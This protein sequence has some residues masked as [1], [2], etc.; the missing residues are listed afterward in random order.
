MRMAFRTLRVGSSLGLSS[1]VLFL[2][3]GGCSSTVG[4]GTRGDIGGEQYRQLETAAITPPEQS[5]IERASHAIQT[6]FLIVMENHN[7]S[8]IAGNASAP[9]INGTLL[10]MGAH[11]EHYVNGAVHPSEPNYVWLEAGDALGISNDAA[12]AYNDR[13]THAH[14]S[15]FLDGA[16]VSWKSYQEDIAPDTC[17]LSASGLY[18]PKHNPM[19][20]F[21]DV[22]ADC[23][24]HVRPYGELARDLA[25]GTVAAYNFITPNLCDDMHNADGCATGDAVANGDAWLAREVPVILASEAYQKGGAL[26]ITWDEGG[27]SESPL[28]MIVL[29]PFAK[30]GYAGQLPYTHSS[31][32]RTVQEVLAVRP[33]LRAA[34]DSPSLSDLFVTYP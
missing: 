25:S 23:A 20:F 18:D 8:Q 16:G 19:V 34:A 22:R 17:P 10:P 15:A 26:F 5:R 14:L 24:T 13:S 9:Y 6:V 31:T 29:S 30:A 7:W 12:P 27:G 2:V 32:L 28:G 11:A 21:D 1:M 3:G 33:F 4:S